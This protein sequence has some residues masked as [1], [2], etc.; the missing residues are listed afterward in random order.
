MPPRI[1]AF[2]ARHIWDA[3]FL[4]QHV[5]QVIVADDRPG[6]PAENFVWA[7]DHGQTGQFLHGYR[8]VWLPA[9]LLEKA[10]QPTLVEALFAASRHWRIS[11]HFNKGLAGA[12]A[13]DLAEARDTAMNPAVLEAFA[14]AILGAGGP[15]AF[16]GISNPPDLT[17]ARRNAAANGRAMNELS[18][19]VTQPGAYVS[20]SDFFEREWQRSFWGPNY[21]RLV[22]VKQRYDPDG[23]FFVHH[24]VGSEAWTDD[25]FGGR[26]R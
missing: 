16:A 1:A 7:G 10:Q 23:L 21:P 6:A 14:L 26:D 2:P 9:S 25:G 8:S 24:G 20:E 19:V 17:V 15:P 18:K 13:D 3:K 5:P 4:K 22:A 11:L 12:S